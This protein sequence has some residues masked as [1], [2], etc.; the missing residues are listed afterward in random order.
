MQTVP[1]HFIQVT[2]ILSVTRMQIA[3]IIIKLSIYSIC[4]T[5]RYR[6]S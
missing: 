6:Q 2:G 1:P 3:E 4:A 5:H